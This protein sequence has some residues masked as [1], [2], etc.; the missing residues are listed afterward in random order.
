[1]KVTRIIFILAALVVAASAQPNSQSAAEQR[2]FNLED[3]V[4]ISAMLSD[5]EL[6]ALAND[7]LMRKELA[8]APSGSKPTPLTQDGLAATVVH[9]CGSGERDLVVIGDGAPYV[10]ANIGPFWIIRDLPAGPVV[11][12]GE[13]SLSLTVETKRSNKCLNVETCAATAADGTT[14]DYSFNGTRYIVSKQKT[15]KLAQ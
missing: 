2:F 13:T 1:M 4:Q 14:T 12:L 10:G 6:A 15:A 8:P 5:T 9:L 11:V 3:A 7:D